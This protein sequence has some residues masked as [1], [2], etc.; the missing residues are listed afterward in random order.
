M[1]D[2]TQL[3]LQVLPY[4]HCSC[5]HCCCSRQQQRLLWQLQGLTVG[6][7]R[8]YGWQLQLQL[9]GPAAREVLGR[10]LLQIPREAGGMLV[11]SCAALPTQGQTQVVWVPVAATGAAAVA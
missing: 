3:L 11:P 7:A 1:A 8:G 9:C 4:H 2:C 5:N 10:Q 6:A